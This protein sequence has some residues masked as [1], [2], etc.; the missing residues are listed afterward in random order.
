LFVDPNRLFVDGHFSF[1]FQY[2]NLVAG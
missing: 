1:L 2:H